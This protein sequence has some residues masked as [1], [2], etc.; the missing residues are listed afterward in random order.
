MGLGWG[1]GGTGASLETLV[2]PKCFWLETRLWSALSHPTHYRGSPETHCCSF[3][4]Q[5]WGL[6]QLSGSGLRVWGYMG[7]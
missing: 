5:L 7:I 6:S 2:F 4:E 1:E 3:K